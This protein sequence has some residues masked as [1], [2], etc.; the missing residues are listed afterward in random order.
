MLVHILENCSLARRLLTLAKMMWQKRLVVLRA[1]QAGPHLWP[2]AWLPLGEIRL[3][4]RSSDFFQS[5]PIARTPCRKGAAVQH[6]SL[7]DSGAGA[8][9]EPWL[10]HLVANAAQCCI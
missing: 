2:I 8:V 5:L 1:G 3:Y 4:R 7:K 10:D 9:G 6:A